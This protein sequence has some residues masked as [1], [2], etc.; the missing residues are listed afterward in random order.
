MSKVATKW[1]SWIRTCKLQLQGTEQATTPPHYSGDPVS[2]IICSFGS[3]R[4]YHCSWLCELCAHIMVIDVVY[5]Y[6][7][8]SSLTYCNSLVFHWTFNLFCPIATQETYLTLSH[9]LLVMTNYHALSPLRVFYML[10]WL[11]CVK[12]LT[13]IC[14]KSVTIF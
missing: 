11:V 4:W 10:I 9:T 2:R 13:I 12:R 14:L 7:L 5:W 8:S 1:P 6:W 3:T